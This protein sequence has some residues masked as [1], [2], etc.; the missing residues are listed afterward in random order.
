VKHSEIVDEY[1]Q[2]K[3]KGEKWNILLKNERLERKTGPVWG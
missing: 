3:G 2:E 1:A